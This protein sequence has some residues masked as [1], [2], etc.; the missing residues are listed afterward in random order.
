MV[1]MPGL[2]IVGLQWGDEGKGKIVDVY[3]ERAQAVVR[4]AGGA[5]AGHTLSVGG[6]K[7]VLHL[8]PSGI[9]RPGVHCYLAAGMVVDPTALLAE[10]QE[11]DRAGLEPW[12]R[13]SVSPAAHVVTPFHKARD[14]LR[15]RGGDRI[16][17]TLRGIGPAYADRASRWG[18]PVAWLRDRQRMESALRRQAEAL[19]SSDEP[20]PSVSDVLEDLLQA[21]ERLRPLVRDVRSAVS[22]HLEKGDLVL[23]EGAQ[24]A[25]L[26]ILHGTYPHVTSSQTLAASAA[27]ATGLGPGAV[28]RVLGVAKAYTT[29]VGLGPFPSEANQ[30]AQAWLRD[31]GGEYGSTTGRPRRCGWL[32][33]PALRTA[34][35]LNGVTE[36]AITK[37]DVLTGLPHI[38]VAVAYDL[39]GQRLSQVPE[40][41]L[42]WHR[43][44]PVWHETP[45][46]ETLP[47]HPGRLEDLPGPARD[48][49]ALIERATGVPIRIVSVGPERD[50]ILWTHQEASTRQETSKK[51]D[52]EGV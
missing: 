32:D 40:D 20:L 13:V 51:K 48:Y 39:D 44:T 21:G 28:D 24:G 47:V 12:A 37:L 19:P 30:E 7:H 27:A 10:L 4:F 9:A 49:L 23:F 17:T 50:A 22:G 33:L 18:I 2:A 31:R 15:E 5:N 52:E 11:C 43:L 25:L 29:R 35:R 45:G 3:A 42:C 38:R 16:G 8:L 34:C 46:W 36:L 1:T 14:R 26:D 6:S 41:P